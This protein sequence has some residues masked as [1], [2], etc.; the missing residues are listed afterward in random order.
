MLGFWL[1]AAFL[2]LSSLIVI[3]ITLLRTHNNIKLEHGAELYKQRLLELETDI[4]NGLLSKTEIENVKKEMQLS[5][6]NQDKNNNEQRIES[7]SETE[8]K[9]PIITAI[10][11]LILLPVFVIGM[12]NHLGRPELIKQASL[13]SDDDCYD[14]SS[15]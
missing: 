1:M 12:Y 9:S 4:E 11:L 6:L 15:N 2:L 7:T 3:L 14:E 10:L 8:L 13:L 5:L